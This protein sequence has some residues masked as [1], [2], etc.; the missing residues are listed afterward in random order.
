MKEKEKRTEKGICHACMK[1]KDW[2]KYERGQ[3]IDRY[4][5]KGQKER[6]R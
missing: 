1:K 2:G 6:Y 4:K 5:K 3:C